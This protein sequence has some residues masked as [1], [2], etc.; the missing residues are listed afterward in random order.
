[1]FNLLIFSSKDSWAKSPTEFDRSRIAVEY[2]ANEISERYKS[3]DET[4]IDELKRFPTLFVTEN[5]KTESRIGRI[6]EI[7]LRSSNVLISFEFDPIFPPLPKGAIEN[8]CTDIDLGRQELSRTHWAIKDEPIIE[9]LIKRGYITP[10]QVKESQQRYPYPQPLPTPP[11]EL[12]TMVALGIMLLIV[13][14]I[15]A[16]VAYNTDTTVTT[17]L[18]FIGDSYIG[19][20]TVHNIGKMDKRQNDLML[21]ALVVVVGVILFAVGKTKESFN[22]TQLEANASLD[23]RKCPF[24]AELIK[25]E[26]VICRFCQKDLPPT[27]D[28]TESTSTQSPLSTQMDSNK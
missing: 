15:W 13:G 21:S 16:L 8:I 28:I 18:R 4:A 1:M 6:T 9:I 19:G 27:P 3:L 11:G 17:P 10:E 7:R 24:C 25:R 23:T 26:A 12:N 2:T 20:E 22:T 14:T 5:E